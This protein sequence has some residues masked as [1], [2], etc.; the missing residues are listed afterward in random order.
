MGGLHTQG[1]GPQ[2]L[3]RTPCN[4][5]ND[6]PMASSFLTLTMNESMS[7]HCKHKYHSQLA[8]H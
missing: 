6:L 5:S 1:Q 4:T 7:Y 3:P 8:C 2:A